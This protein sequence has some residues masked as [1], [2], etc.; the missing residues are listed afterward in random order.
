MLRGFWLRVCLGVSCGVVLSVAGSGQALAWGPVT[1]QEIVAEA[2]DNMP[3]GELKRLWLAYPDAM[4][5]GAI[6]P[7]WCL[8]YA[9]LNP[10]DAA[11]VASHQPDFHR[12]EFLGALAVLAGTDSERAFYC[13]YQSHVLADEYEGDF[14]ATVSNKPDDYSLEFYVDRMVIADYHGAVRIG[15]PAGLMVAAYRTAFP[16]SR[17]Q[18]TAA[19][20]ETLYLANWLYQA[21]WLPHIS[22]I[23]LEKGRE[24]Y[25][26]Y[27]GFVD[28]AAQEAARL[29]APV[30]RLGAE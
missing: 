1:H 4:Y 19:Q 12:P 29:D 7:D 21:L 22:G 25:A 9:R 6:A 23:D 8:A 2:R 11:G 5:G 15:L 3:G 30:A 18:P 20:I 24:Y 10:G 26:T 17:W 14:G 28:A 16:E 13:A 27:A